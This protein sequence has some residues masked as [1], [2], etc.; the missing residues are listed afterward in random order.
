M[1]QYRQAK[2]A[3]AVSVRFVFGESVFM[4]SL[5]QRAGLALMCAA[6]LAACGGSGSGNMT[7]GG[8]VV[9]LT[10]PDLAVTNG[11]VTLPIPANTSTFY[12]T[13]LIAADQP[14]DIEISHQPT[15]AKCT[16]ANNKNK[17][18]VYTVS[19]TVIT[20]VTD[21]YTLG[22]TVSG[23]SGTG[24]IVANGSN[25]APVLPPAVANTDV[26]FSFPLPVADGA[27]YGVTILAQPTG[28]T[29]AVSNPTGVMPAGEYR[30]LAIVCK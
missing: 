8:A 14:F 19:Q 4:K 11:G 29:C 10:K 2:L 23:L 12:F 9:G 3:P 26:D 20:C 17:A 21:S 30:K 25:N 5:Y 6:T 7:L 18:N 28:Q 27:N 24:L 15:G 13:E 22:G 16:I 1:Q